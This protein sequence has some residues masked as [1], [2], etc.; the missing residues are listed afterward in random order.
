MCG[1][2]VILQDGID[3]V[4][5]TPPA[6]M[7]MKES[8]KETHRSHFGLAEV[9]P[10]FCVFKLASSGKLAE[11]KELARNIAQVLDYDFARVDRLV[12]FF[13]DRDERPFAT[14][15]AD[16][17][18]KRHDG[19]LD[20]HRQYQSQAIALGRRAEVIKEYRERLRLQ[21]D[22]A[23]AAYLLGR[24]LT[25]P[26]GDRF[27]SE[28]QQRFPR[29]AYLLRSAAYRALNRADFAEVERLVEQLRSVDAKSWQ[30][31]VDLACHA[32]AAAGKIEQAR[33]LV[34]DCLRSPN[35][36]ASD[37]FDAVVDA[38]LLGHL[39]P[40]SPSD[41]L[42][43]PLQGDNPAE[44]SELHVV[45]RVHGCEPVPTSELEQL[46]DKALKARL[47]LELL[48]RTEPNAALARVSSGS[49]ASPGISAAAW[50]L[51]LAEAARLDEH[52]PALAHLQ[53]WSP[54]GRAGATAFVDYALHG[55][56][57]EELEELTPEMRAAADFV[58]SRALPAGSTERQALRDRAARED[59]LHGAVSAAMNQW[60]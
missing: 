47:E 31:T 45:A 41:S 9:P 43:G 11:S 55:T 60:P 12:D 10:M 26:E 46:E 50:A 51:L 23:D 42:L 28:S 24:V 34:K 40:K 29:H 27:V 56:A 25:G 8:E 1:Q 44:T 33:E 35:L 49:D 59:M 32:L 20:Y 54:T 48:A 17:G 15:L 16:A 38:E 22:S 7:S 3:Y 2:R 57:N 5:T 58:R 36:S 53:R 39:E 21:P 14:E 6:E 30:G 37:R 19:A 52:H 4:F 13:D 18:R